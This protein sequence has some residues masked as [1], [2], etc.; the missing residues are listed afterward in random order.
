M[1]ASSD[2]SARSVVEVLA[3]P[4]S[5]W[6]G[7]GFLVHSLASYHEDAEAISPFLLLDY[8]PP[9]EF[10]PTLEQRGVGS[11]PHRG[12]ETVT[13]AFQ[14]SVEHQDSGGH[15]GRIGPGDVQWMTAGRGVVHQEFHGRDFAES[16]GTFEMAQIWVDLPRD[17][18]MT[19]PRYQTLRSDRIPVL[20]LQGG[21]GQAR[22]IS[23]TLHG[24]QGPARTFS[25]I[26]LWDLDLAAGAALDLPLPSGHTALLLVRRGSVR[27][28]GTLVPANQLARLAREGSSVS[29]ATEEAAQ[30]LL[31]SGEPLPGPV[32]GHGPFVMSSRREILEAIA[33]FQAGR[34]GEIPAPATPP[35]PDPAHPEEPRD[36]G[37]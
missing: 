35:P 28:A 8:A 30:I 20:E 15:V 16:G 14:G 11:H 31:L 7:D 37:A 26:A 18:K 34:F 19:A 23:G 25:P 27:A 29:I 32:V 17:H 3:P 5:H 12:F 21:A 33:D 4:R 24:V 36:R 10:A 2:P 9:R 6:V 22:V 13:I 1:P